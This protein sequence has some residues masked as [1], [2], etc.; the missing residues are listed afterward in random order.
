M[1]SRSSIAALLLCL[2]FAVSAFP[3][4][5]NGS[6]GGIIQGTATTAKAAAVNALGNPVAPQ[7]AP[8]STTAPY[9]G[10]RFSF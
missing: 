5:S 9:T 3:Q 2:L 6:M 10:L 1:K 8:G 4:S 7:F